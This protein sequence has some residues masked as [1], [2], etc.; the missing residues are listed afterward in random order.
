M[1]NSSLN[2]N[3]KTDMNILCIA[4]SIQMIQS[5]ASQ[6]LFCKHG[7]NLVSDF[8]VNYDTTLVFPANASCG[9]EK[10]LILT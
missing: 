1:P 8:G 2:L 9:A 6:L 4:T 3:T 10:S 5:K 7:I